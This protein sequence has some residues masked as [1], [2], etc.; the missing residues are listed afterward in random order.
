MNRADRRTG[1]SVWTGAILLPEPRFADGAMPVGRVAQSVDG[2]PAL[3]P[4][5]LQGWDRAVTRSSGNS[6]DRYSLTPN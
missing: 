4:R 2:Y 5:S 3:A 6:Y 1:A